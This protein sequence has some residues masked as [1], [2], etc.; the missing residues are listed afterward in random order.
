MQK[1]KNITNSKNILEETRN[2]LE[3]ENSKKKKKL[4]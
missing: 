4:F 2:H 3:E 1:T